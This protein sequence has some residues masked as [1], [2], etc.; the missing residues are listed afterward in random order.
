MITTSIK[1]TAAIFKFVRELKETIPNSYFYYRKQFNLKEIIEQA[2][3]KGFTAVIVVHERLR[4]PYRLIV[5]HLPNGPTMEFKISN[6]IYH[7]QIHD[8]GK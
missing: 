5:T 2:K 7:D 6:V 4:K 8:V 3:E 1:H